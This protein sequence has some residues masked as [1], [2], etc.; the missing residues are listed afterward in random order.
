MPAAMSGCWPNRQLEPTSVRPICCASPTS[1]ACICSAPSTSVATSAAAPLNTDD[2]P[3][4]EFNAPRYLYAETTLDNLARLIEQRPPT[5]QPVPVRSLIAQQVERRA[6][7][8][9]VLVPSEAEQPAE[10][11]WQTR[12]S[13]LVSASGSSQPTFAVLQERSVLF[14][15]RRR[16]PRCWSSPRSSGNGTETELRDHL[17]AR[18]STADDESAEQLML[19]DGTPALWAAGNQLNAQ[20]GLAWR[21][22]AAE[23][24]YVVLVPMPEGNNRPAMAERAR[25][26]AAQLSCSPAPAALAL[27]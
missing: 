20:L 12:W 17:T 14:A 7:V 2:R 4:V 27:D 23:R 11:R 16:P 5:S 10:A 3:R 18:V 19:A 1:L 9:G 21:C 24:Y 25:Q 6:S 8:F 26:L 22:A 15:A 13:R